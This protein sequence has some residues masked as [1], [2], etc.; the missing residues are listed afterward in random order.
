[1]HRESVSS[2]VERKQENE[3]YGQGK[4]LKNKE[5]GRK[6]Q[7]LIQFNVLRPLYNLVL[8]RMMMLHRRLCWT[9]QKPG[10]QTKTVD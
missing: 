9:I 1:M 6:Q 8:N 10:G 7:H 4:Q 2:Y 5:K 3:C